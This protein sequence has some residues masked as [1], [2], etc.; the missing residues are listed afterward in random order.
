MSIHT[1]KRWGAAL[2]W[3]LGQMIL[4]I[5][6]DDPWLGEGNQKT[7]FETTP[8][9]ESVVSLKKVKGNGFQNS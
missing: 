1:N 7:E 5:C 9:F 8:R 6:I 4:I 3:A 2:R